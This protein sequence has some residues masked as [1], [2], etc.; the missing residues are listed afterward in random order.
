MRP[1]LNIILERKAE[2][3]I[4]GPNW[5]L[6]FPNVDERVTRAFPFDSMADGS[7]HTF[8]M[9]HVRDAKD[10]RTCM[11][12]RLADGPSEWHTRNA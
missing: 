8:Q 7:P 1:T 9:S 5:I 4:L 11:S 6:L 10:R 3:S 12:E 2:V